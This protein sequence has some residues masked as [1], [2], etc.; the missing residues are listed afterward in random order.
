MEIEYRILAVKE[1]EDLVRDL[2]L[3]LPQDR[4]RV[5]WDTE[6]RGCMW[7]AVRAWETYKEL[8]ADKGSAG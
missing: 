6:H 8:P 1:R 7:N 3:K 4:T 2:V 5:M